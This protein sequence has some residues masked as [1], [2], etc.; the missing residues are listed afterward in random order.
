[1]A[2]NEIKL[3]ARFVLEVLA[4]KKQIHDLDDVTASRISSS[5]PFEEKLNQGRLIETVTVQKFQDED[6]D[7]ITFVFGKPDPAVSEFKSS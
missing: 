4:G 5:N 2:D 7:Y 3:S 6:D 1:M